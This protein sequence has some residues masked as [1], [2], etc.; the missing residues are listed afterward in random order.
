ML[1]HVVLSLLAPSTC[2]AFSAPTPRAGSSCRHRLHASPRCCELSPASAALE[3][4]VIE[5]ARRGAPDA[6]VREAVAVLIAE[7]GGGLAPEPALSPL[8]EG[9]WKLLS[10]SGSEFDPRNPLGRR[11]D[12]TA[13]GLEGFFARISGGD[14]VVAA[15]SSPIQ[16]AVTSAFSVVQTLRGLG[17]DA[18]RVEQVVETPVGSLHLNA[19]AR[20]D[21]SEPQRV[22]FAFDEGYFAFRSSSLRL[23]YP[24]PFRLLGKE[25]EGYLDTSYLGERLRVSTGN[26]GTTFM[27]ERLGASEGSGGAP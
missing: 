7:A 5:L 24:V 2:A 4:E 19:A 16:R 17:S 27:L 23:P 20:V 10:T 11:L 21:P 26:K 25:A 12:G 9:E 22:R 18:G 8:L 15:S 1:L 3:A 13:P 6:A 14:Q